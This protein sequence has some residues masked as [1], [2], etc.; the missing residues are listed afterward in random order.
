MKVLKYKD[1]NGEY[2]IITPIVI[3]NS[4]ALA[5]VDTE[6][7][8]A[9]EAEKDLESKIDDETKRAKSAESNLEEKL[10]DINDIFSSGKEGQT[11]TKTKDGVEWSDL[12]IE[13]GSEEYSIQQINCNA[14]GYN[15]SAF[16]N[17]TYAIGINSF[18]EGSKS[19]ANGKNSHA[20]GYSSHSV[21]GSSHAEGNETVAEGSASHSEGYNTASKGTYSHAEGYYTKAN[22]AYS[23]AEGGTT[24]ANNFCEHAQGQFNKSN[25]TSDSFGNAGNTLH[26][27]GIGERQGKEKNAFEIMQNGDAY[28]YGLG[29]YDGTNPSSAQPIASVVKPNLDIH[30]KITEENNGLKIE[31]G[32][33]MDWLRQMYDNNPID[34]KCFVRI[35]DE[36]TRHIVIPNK[37]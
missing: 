27:V 36:R 37:I 35:Y 9:I 16:G 25:K 21:G 31:H 1:S 12:N 29:G 7:N 17:E 28:F 13:N 8:R 18:A 26:S 32:D 6:E 3:D 4:E 30:L 24:L 10:D 11:L 23:H 33:N 5:R 19:Q 34:E 15:S 22:G 14:V 20:E 2:Q